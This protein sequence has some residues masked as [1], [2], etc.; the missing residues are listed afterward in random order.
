[1]EELPVYYVQLPGLNRNW[2]LFREMQ[3]EVSQEMPGVGMAVTIDVGHP[4][5]VHPNKKKPVG[6]RL[7]GLALGNT[8]G[9]EIVCESPVVRQVKF[10]KHLA[11]VEFD[12]RVVTKG[13]ENVLGFE[14]AGEDRVFHPAMVMIQRKTIAVRSD[15]VKEVVAVRYAW[16]NDPKANLTN[17]EG[18][19]VGPFRSDDWPVAK[20]TK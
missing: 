10:D 3:L 4:T 6:D 2:P 14:V 20:K 1:M 17:R 19:P 13:N 11:W 7:A 18:L 5:N 12:Q 9:R 15:E 16:A 8:Y